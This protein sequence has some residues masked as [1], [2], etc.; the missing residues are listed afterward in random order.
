V[1]F[2]PAIDA[3]INDL[4]PISIAQIAS[5]HFRGLPPTNCKIVPATECLNEP[6]NSLAWQEVRQSNAITADF[7]VAKSR[8]TTRQT[9]VRSTPK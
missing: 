2:V 5:A 9:S 3:P 1:G 4:S 7:N 6:A 8:S